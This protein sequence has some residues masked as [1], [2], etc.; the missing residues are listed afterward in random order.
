MKSTEWITE[1]ETYLTVVKNRVSNTVRSYISDI[2]LLHKFALAGRSEDW[3]KFTEQNAVDYVGYLKK[4][5]RDTAVSRK[6]YALRGF[7]KFLRK[8]QVIGP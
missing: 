3:G 7:F 4:T 5:S 8:K 2:C 1:Y 6:V